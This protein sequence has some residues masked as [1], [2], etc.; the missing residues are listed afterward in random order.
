MMRIKPAT[1][2]RS[3]TAVGLLIFCVL[4]LLYDDLPSEYARFILV[5]YV[6]IWLVV[7]AWL[8]IPVAVIQYAA[9]KKRHEVFSH[10]KQ[11]SLKEV[12]GGNH[13]E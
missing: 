1:L 11:S 12:K 6:V 10:L 9:Q 13:D 3:V 8:F 5:G 7:T 4:L 2:V